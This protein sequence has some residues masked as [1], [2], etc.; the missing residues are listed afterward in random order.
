MWKTINKVLDK[1]NTSAPLNSV[2]LNGQKYVRPDEIAEA[3]NEHFVTVAGADPD[4]WVTDA[5]R[6][7]TKIEGE[8]AR[9]DETTKRRTTII[10][11]ADL[12][13]NSSLW[14]TS[15]NPCKTLIFLHSGVWGPIHFGYR[16]LRRKELPKLL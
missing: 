13:L 7:G 2:T 5:S 8:E 16:L 6:T 4:I 10:E 9:G 3:F 15:V 14:T 12:L 11:E 1:C